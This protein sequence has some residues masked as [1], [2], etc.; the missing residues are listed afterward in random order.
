MVEILRE[1]ISFKPYLANF[2]NT[3]LTID[4]V[5][6]FA[7][8]YNLG[9]RV[10]LSVEGVKRLAVEAL[11]TLHVPIPLTATALLVLSLGLRYGKGK[12]IITGLLCSGD[13]IGTGIGG[14]HAWEDR[15]VSDEEVVS[16]IDLSVKIN[17]SCTTLATVILAK[18]VGSNPVIGTAIAPRD[19]H[20]YALLD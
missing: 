13:E 14:D 16:A 12:D 4:I 1:D 6:R 10:A 5:K 2:L 17:N 7:N 8:S 19:D 11:A 9:I 15:C 20:L 18:L 3:R